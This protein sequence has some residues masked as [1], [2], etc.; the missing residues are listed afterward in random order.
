MRTELAAACMVVV[1]GAGCNDCGDYT[2]KGV[3]N[4]EWCGAVYGTKGTWYDDDD[5]DGADV[6]GQGTIVLQFGHDVPPGATT[7]L[8]TGSVEAYV[9]VDELSD[10]LTFTEATP[11]VLCTWTDLVDPQ[12]PD[13]DVE[14]VEEPATAYELTYDGWRL[15]LGTAPTRAF[16]WSIT[17]GDGV[18]T[19]EGSDRVD[20]DTVNGVHARYAELAATG[21]LRTESSAPDD[22][23]S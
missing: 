7:F 18:W 8:H 1:L 15:P 6:D 5:A 12:N 4:D 11:R 10:G 9:L 16:S 2:Y 21:V 22:T 20:L 3:S 14:H 19:L 23:G 13:D 17:C